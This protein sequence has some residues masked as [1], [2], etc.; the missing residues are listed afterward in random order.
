MYRTTVIVI[1]L[2]ACAFMVSCEEPKSEHQYPYGVWRPEV[3][4]SRDNWVWQTDTLSSDL[5]SGDVVIEITKS[6]F[7]YWR[8]LPKP[9]SDALEFVAFGGSCEITDEVVRV[10]NSQ[11][12]SQVTEFEYF[13]SGDTLILQ[14]YLYPQGEFAEKT[15]YLDYSEQF[16]K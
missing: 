7:T 3:V 16:P 11:D 9:F 14:T 6:L 13:F 1:L 2:A 15:L 8:L 5:D 12:Y 4:F 10:R